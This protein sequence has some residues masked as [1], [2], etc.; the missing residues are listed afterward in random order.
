M[1]RPRAGEHCPFD[2]GSEFFCLLGLTI[3]DIF[4]FVY[5]F[6]LC[7]EDLPR[8]IFLGCQF[9]FPYYK[10]N[11]PSCQGEMRIAG[12]FIP[13]LYLCSGSSYNYKIYFD[14]WRML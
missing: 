10:K 9:E 14:K 12:F 4:P 13:V 5:Q 6:F 1:D 11:A 7:Y 3:S 2:I 8:Q